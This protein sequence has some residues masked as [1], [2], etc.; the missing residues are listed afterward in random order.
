MLVNKMSEIS[1]LFLSFSLSVGGGVSAVRKG[2]G[3]APGVRQPGPAADRR[4][5][6]RHFGTSRQ[7]AG[8][9]QLTNQLHTHR[10]AGAHT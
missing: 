10:V 1:P 9:Q 3:G 7:R 6:P 5:M 2:G 8:G 4:P